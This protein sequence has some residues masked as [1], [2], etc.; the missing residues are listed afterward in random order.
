MRYLLTLP[1]NFIPGV[2]TAFFLAYNGQHAGPS[3]HNRYFQLKGLSKAE[4]EA[5]V[6]QRRGAYTSFVPSSFPND[7]C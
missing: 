4:R 3:H 6:T 5:F 1:L 2:G 7:E